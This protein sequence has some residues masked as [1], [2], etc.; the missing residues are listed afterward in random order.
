[1]QFISDSCFVVVVVAKMLA[2]DEVGVPV[3]VRPLLLAGQRWRMAVREL[4][5]VGLFG[6]EDVIGRTDNC[7]YRTKVKKTSPLMLPR[8]PPP[9]HDVEW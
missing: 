4:V 2:E 5:R 8:T 3:A 7:L 1:M 6:D 9:R